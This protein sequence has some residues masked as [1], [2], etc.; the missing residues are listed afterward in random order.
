M[1]EKELVTLSLTMDQAGYVIEALAARCDAL[2]SELTSANF[3]KRVAQNKIATLEK[4]LASAD[5][6][7]T[8]EKK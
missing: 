4:K 1:A 5:S 8:K 3:D 6:K 2:D 7:L